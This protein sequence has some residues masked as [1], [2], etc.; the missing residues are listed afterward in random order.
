MVQEQEVGASRKDFW[1]FMWI[2]EDLWKAFTRTVYVEIS[3][4]DDGR[5]LCDCMR[6]TVGTWKTC[7]YY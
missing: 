4:S 1:K 2:Q 3:K 7:V 6:A 5:S